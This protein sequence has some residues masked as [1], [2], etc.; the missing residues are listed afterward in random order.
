[1]DIK[2]TYSVE[3]VAAVRVYRSCSTIDGAQKDLERRAELKGAITDLFVH[4]GCALTAT[5]ALT[6]EGSRLRKR[7]VVPE[8]HLQESSR[9]LAVLRRAQILAEER[10]HMVLKS[11]GD[12]AGVSTLID[13]EAVG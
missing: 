10:N 13:L 6:G 11:I 8:I 9:L 2:R 12:G 3:S 1:M 4:H 5:H 7:S